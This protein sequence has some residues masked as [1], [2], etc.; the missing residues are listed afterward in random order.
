M[1][2]LRNKQTKKAQ[3]RSIFMPQEMKKGRTIQST[4]AEENNKNLC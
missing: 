3:K 1:P 4:F 2:L